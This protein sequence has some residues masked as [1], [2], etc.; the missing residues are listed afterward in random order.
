MLVLPGIPH[1]ASLSRAP[2]SLCCVVPDRNGR[3]ALP[4]KTALKEHLARSQRHGTR[5]EGGKLASESRRGK[6][7]LGKGCR[8]RRASTALNCQRAASCDPGEEFS[9]LGSNSPS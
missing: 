3:Q 2:D 4:K 9:I 1:P 7:D 8:R 6:V 5:D